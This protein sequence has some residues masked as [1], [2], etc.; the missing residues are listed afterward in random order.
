M[1]PSK[2]NELISKTYQGILP[3]KLLANFIEDCNEAYHP[4]F[5]TDS[6]IKKSTSVVAITSNKAGIFHQFNHFIKNYLKQSK[7]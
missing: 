7:N 6:I 1:K 2:N 5:A 3:R 4:I